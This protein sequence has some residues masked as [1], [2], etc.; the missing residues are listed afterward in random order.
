MFG[1]TLPS[2]SFLIL[3]SLEGSYSELLLYVVLTEGIRRSNSPFCGNI[4]CI[5]NLSLLSY[6]LINN[7]LC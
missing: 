7:Y 5:G 2:L 4:F 6:L 1:F 3:E